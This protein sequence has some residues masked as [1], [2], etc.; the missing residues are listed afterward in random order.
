VARVRSGRHA[1]GAE[2]PAARAL[3]LVLSLELADHFVVPAHFFPP[4][5]EPGDADPADDDPR[6]E[7]G[8]DGDERRLLLFLAHA[9]GKLGWACGGSELAATRL[10]RIR[11]GFAD[12]LG[13]TTVAERR[14]QKRDHQSSDRPEP[15]DL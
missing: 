8:S 7:Q 3:E 12:P 10:L 11:D 9:G 4:D 2:A 1:G 5:E 15:H 6:H 14:D 13:L